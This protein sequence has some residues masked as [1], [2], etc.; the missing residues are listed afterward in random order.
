M[1]SQYQTM[2]PMVSKILCTNRIPCKTKGGMRE[3]NLKKS[4]MNSVYLGEDMIVSGYESGNIWDYY[5]IFV[6]TCLLNDPW[7]IIIWCIWCISWYF[8]TV[9][10]SQVFHH[11]IYWMRKSLRDWHHSSFMN[12]KLKSLFLCA[13]CPA[14]FVSRAKV[15]QTNTE[16]KHWPRTVQNLLEWCFL[17][18]SKICLIGTPSTYSFVYTQNA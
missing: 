9:Y 16:R 4:I 3:A 11:C 2:F 12:L 18:C 1:N 5:H 7:M 17:N 13:L 15:L 10:A 6:I 14:Q 8:V